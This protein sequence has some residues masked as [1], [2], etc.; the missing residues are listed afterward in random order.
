MNIY[1]TRV[2]YKL[3]FDLLIVNINFLIYAMVMVINKHCFFK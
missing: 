2:N 3:C 1:I